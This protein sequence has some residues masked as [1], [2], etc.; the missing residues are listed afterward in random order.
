MNYLGVYDGKCNPVSIVKVSKGAVVHRNKVGRFLDR[1]NYGQ[2]VFM[3][4]PLAMVISGELLQ[5][6]VI[7]VGAS[8]FI[9]Q[10]FQIVNLCRQLHPAKC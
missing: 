8:S 1:D 9:V 5:A 6:L 10:N 4:P 3:R 7:L 2:M